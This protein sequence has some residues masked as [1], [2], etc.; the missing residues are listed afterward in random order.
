MSK[1]HGENKKVSFP[2]YPA[3]PRKKTSQTL[4][5]EEDGC[6]KFESQ[7]E[8]QSETLF[9]KERDKREREG[10]QKEGRAKEA[11]REWEHN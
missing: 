11:R 8:L 5:G 3:P 6:C 2:I 1:P 4:E 9:Q 7:S 10:E